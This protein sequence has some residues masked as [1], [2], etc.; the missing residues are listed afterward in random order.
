MKLSKLGIER[1]LRIS[2]ILLILGLV[3]EAFS[4]LWDKP[5]AFV[6]FVGVGGFL[7][8]VGILVYL[9]SLVPSNSPPQG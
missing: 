5:L 1:A 3:V 9:C 2:G 7:T 6:V 8:L 4:L